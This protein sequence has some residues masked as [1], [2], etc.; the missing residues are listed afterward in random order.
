[1]NNNKITRAFKSQNNN[2]RVCRK[3]LNICVSVN[4][5]ANGIYTQNKFT[6]E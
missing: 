3:K 5:T 2:I 6:V 4:F 1:V